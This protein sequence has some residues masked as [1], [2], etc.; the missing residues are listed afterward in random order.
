MYPGLTDAV[1]VT[2]YGFSVAG[3]T[4]IACPE[5]FYNCG[6]YSTTTTPAAFTTFTAISVTTPG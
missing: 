2:N 1:K 6:G 3:T 5:G 4:C